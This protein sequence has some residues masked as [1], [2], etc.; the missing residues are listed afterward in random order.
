MLTKAKPFLTLTSAI[1]KLRS[2]NVALKVALESNAY[3]KLFVDTITENFTESHSRP[4]TME[5]REK[6][7][8]QMVRTLVDT[9]AVR[10]VTRPML[11]PGDVVDEMRD[12]EDR[13]LRM[14]DNFQA[15]QDQLDDNIKHVAMKCKRMDL[16]L[17]QMKYQKYLVECNIDRLTERIKGKKKWLTAPYI[18]IEMKFCCQTF[19]EG[20]NERGFFD[21]E[22]LLM[23]LRHHVRRIYRQNV[24]MTDIE[25]NGTYTFTA[26]QLSYFSRHS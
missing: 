17:K 10:V 19:A 3:M 4:I 16:E 13:N 22:E 11:E 6:R 15:S 2:G 7:T 14:I 9:A 24:C 1:S 18:F 20:D 8:S 25:L 12:L 5:M 21:Q 23:M 26:A